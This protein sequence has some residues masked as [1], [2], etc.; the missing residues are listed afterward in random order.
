L[1]TKR[2][3]VQKESNPYT[4][5]LNLQNEGFAKTGG[6]ITG[7]SI[8]RIQNFSGEECRNKRQNRERSCR[9]AVKWT[10]K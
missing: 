3:G 6:G 9:G 10:I 1:L 8:K 4:K 7:N 2:A 5:V